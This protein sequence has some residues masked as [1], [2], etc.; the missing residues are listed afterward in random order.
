MLEQVPP[1]QHVRPQDPQLFE[2]KSRLTHFPLHG[3]R[4]ELH[5]RTLPEEELELLDEELELLD[6]ELEDELE[7]EELEELLDEELEDELELEELLDDEEE[8][9]DELLDTPLD[10]EENDELEIP[11]ENLEAE[12]LVDKDEELEVAELLDSLLDEGLALLD[13]GLLDP[14]EGLDEEVR[15]KLEL[16]EELTV[17][18]E[19]AVKLVVSLLVP[20]ELPERLALEGTDDALELE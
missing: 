7:D 19:E 10:E 3:V 13:R 11:D 5:V 18:A 6:E 12:E 2:S 17:F 20:K 1:P 9:E 15:D 8:L 16:N 4:P 14:L